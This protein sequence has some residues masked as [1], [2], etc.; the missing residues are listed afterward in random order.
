[1]IPLFRLTRGHSP[2]KTHL[3][4]KSGTRVHWNMPGIEQN[5]PRRAIDMGE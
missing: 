5:V 1:M 3:A 4:D 2:E